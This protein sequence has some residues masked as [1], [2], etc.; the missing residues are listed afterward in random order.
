VVGAALPLSK[1][2]LGKRG[3]M[4]ACF[5]VDNIECITDHEMMFLK[6]LDS[7]SVPAPFP[8]ST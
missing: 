8:L 5:E 6:S 7:T 1:R 2:S 4:H 3:V